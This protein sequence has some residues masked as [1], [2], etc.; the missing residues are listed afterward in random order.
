MTAGVHH[1]VSDDLLMSYAAGSLGEGWSLAVATHVA[2][3]PACRDRLRAAEAVGG[4]LLE[5]LDD[6]AV[7]PG[8]LDSVLARVARPKPA[9]SHPVR[10]AA[11]VED[12]ML[13]PE[14]LRGY[15]ERLGRPTWRKLGGQV[16]EIRIPTGDSGTTC[17]LLRIA[18]GAAVPEHGHRGLELT[19]V[20][21]GRF[22]DGSQCFARGDIEQSDESVQHQPVAE[23]GEDFICLAVT[24]AP[25]R[26]RDWLPR[27]LQP[28][29]RI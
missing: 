12:P 29:L 1:H 27:L 5:T 3:C 20:L 11:G 13:Y 23:P 17:R 14:P 26:F 6:A 7:A 19:L 9:G 2:L 15:L 16:A 10:P 28:V 18:A 24:D 8:A 21:R 25:L 4:A 22:R